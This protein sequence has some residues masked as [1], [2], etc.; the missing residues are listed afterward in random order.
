MYFVLA[1][2]VD[3]SWCSAV[4][5]RGVLTVDL[6]LLNTL[7]ALVCRVPFTLLGPGGSVKDRAALFLISD[8]EQKGK[9]SAGPNRRGSGQRGM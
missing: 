7:S 8:A 5:Q 2:G 4:C 9:A 3:R 6:H 1:R